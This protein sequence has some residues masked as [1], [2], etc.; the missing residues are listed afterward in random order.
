MERAAE[1]DERFIVDR[2]GEPKIVI[3]SVRDFIETIAP[4]PDVLKAIWSESRR[5]GT[6][7]LGLREID[8]EIAAY[9]RKQ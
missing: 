3:M 4:A 2:R 5:K 8:A 6:S 1:R 7:K 9:R